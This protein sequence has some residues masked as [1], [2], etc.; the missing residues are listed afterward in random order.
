LHSTW[1][2]SH[3]FTLGAAQQDT[4]VVAGLALVEQLAEHFHAGAGGLLGVRNTDDFDFFAHFDDAALYPAGH[5][6][7]ASRDGEDVFH[8]HEEGAVN[9]ALG[10]GDVGVQGVGQLH[11]GFFAQGTSCHLPWQA[12]RCRG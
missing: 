11:D 1:P 8:G 3:V 5:H 4:H 9:C 2:R 12:W 7:A 6:G 10:Q